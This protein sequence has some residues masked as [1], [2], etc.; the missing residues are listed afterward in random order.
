VTTAS[1][2]IVSLDTIVPWR[3]SN[4]YYDANVHFSIFMMS[5]D[6]VNGV[7]PPKDIGEGM[8]AVIYAFERGAVSMMLLLHNMHRTNLG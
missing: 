2:N 7:T 4:K 3:I 5:L 1:E 8:P 6:D